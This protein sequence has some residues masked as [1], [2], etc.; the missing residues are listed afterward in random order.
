L[1]KVGPKKTLNTSHLVK[2]GSKNTSQIFGKVCSKKTL[3]QI[4]FAKVGSKNTLHILFGKGWF[5]KHHTSHLVK[6]G[7]K[8]HRR[9]FLVF[10]QKKHFTNHI[11]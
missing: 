2:V 7:S 8:K 9:I 4:T 1:V 6:V 11:W 5:K 3:L 10:V